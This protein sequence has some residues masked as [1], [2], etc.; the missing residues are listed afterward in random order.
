MSPV[1]SAA[2]RTRLSQLV[3]SEAYD[4]EDALEALH[5]PL[6][7][8]VHRNDGAAKQELFNAYRGLSGP[9]KRALQSA[10][11]RAFTKAHGGRTVTMYRRMKSGQTADAMGGLSLTT[12]AP[13]YVS[14]AM[15][16]VAASD[17]LLHWGVSDT[18]LSSRA[19]GH[20]KE[21]ILHAHA[22]PT[23]LGFTPAP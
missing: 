21:V 16:D 23:F 15:F 10:V 9:Q 18:P 13:G 19:F 2:Q 11:N 8:W 12:N 7:D 4:L 17:V 6:S 1:F 5:G 20:E 14:A 3:E 22:N